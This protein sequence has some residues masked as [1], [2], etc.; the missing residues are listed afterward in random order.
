M[1]HRITRVTASENALW[2]K[3]A[4]KHKHNIKT[5]YGLDRLVE[6]LI[7]E[8]MSKGEFNNLSGC[9]KPLRKRD[10]KNPYVDF[11]THKINEVLIDN[12]FVPEWI[13]LQKEI[14]EETA[15]LRDGLMLERSNFG[16]LPFTENDEIHWRDAVNKYEKLVNRINAKIN[17]FNL[18]VPILHK[19][20]IHVSLEKEAKKALVEGKWTNED[21]KQNHK[22]KDLNVKTQEQTLFDLFY[23]LFKS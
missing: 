17:K 20:M 9:G 11:T 16:A 14:R 4:A 23:A 13:S 15:M 19:Q 12:G 21:R 18:V 3:S 5:K 8:S 1:Q 2:D 22:T 6:D 7:Q 10:D